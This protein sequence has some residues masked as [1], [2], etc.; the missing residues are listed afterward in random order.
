ML[1]PIKGILFFMETGHFFQNCFQFFQTL[2]ANSLTV[3]PM[4]FVGGLSY[5]NV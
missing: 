3:F 2:L 5:I 4:K 1:S